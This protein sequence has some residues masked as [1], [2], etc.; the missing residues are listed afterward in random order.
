MGQIEVNDRRATLRLLGLSERKGN[1][2]KSCRPVRKGNG[3]KEVKG[4]QGTRQK[5]WR[6]ES[7]IY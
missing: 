5:I 2:E 1:G 6:K 3:E 4:L 7:L